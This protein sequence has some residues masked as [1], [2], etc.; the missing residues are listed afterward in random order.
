MVDPTSK[1]ILL[2]E[3][4]EDIRLVYA[5]VLRDSG[6]KVLEAVDGNAGLK[7]ALED[8]WDLMLL[9]IMLPGLDGMQILKKVKENDKMKSKPVI[10]LTNLGNENIITEGF[11]LG[12]EGYLIK[13][14][15]TPDKIIEEVQ[16][17]LSK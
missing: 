7:R 11:D 8:G 17:Y 1:T 6:Y 5:E 12:A 10:L 14:E 13:S 2:I 15:I 4:E 16:V 9:D 3:D